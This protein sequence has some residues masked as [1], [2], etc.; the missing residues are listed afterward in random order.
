MKKNNLKTSDI[1]I[2]RNGLTYI[3]TGENLLNL[4]SHQHTN[5]IE[6][7]TPDLRNSGCLGSSLDIVEVK[8]LNMETFTYKT[9]WKRIERFTLTEV[10]ET[11]L[12]FKHMCFDGYV[13]S[14]NDALDLLGEFYVEE[15]G[16]DEFEK[17]IM[18]LEEMDSDVW[19]VK[20]EE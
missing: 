17:N 20:G 2:T 13:T 9:V 6:F 5:L 10:L 14:V 7:L 8:R 4:D 16:C 19:E 3:K 1:L 11:G 18:L 15:F 12:P